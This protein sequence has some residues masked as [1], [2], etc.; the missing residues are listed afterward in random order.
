[1][2]RVTSSA[3]ARHGSDIHGIWAALVHADRFKGVA[4]EDLL[5]L[6]A[7]SAPEPQ[8]RDYLRLRYGDMM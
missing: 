4:L 3:L 1:M 7:A 2:Q 5:P 8:T 6:V